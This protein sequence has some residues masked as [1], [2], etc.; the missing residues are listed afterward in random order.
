MPQFD[1][2]YGEVLT[3]RETSELT[4]FTMNQLR[5]QRQRGNSPLPYV[6]DGITSWYR[7]ADVVKYIET[8]GVLDRTYFVP[9][10]F[11]PAPIEASP[12]TFERREDFTAMAKI[13]TRNAWSKWTE[14]LTQHGGMDINEAY[15]FLEDETVRLYELKHGE[16]LREVHPGQSMDFWLRKN[17]PIRFWEG[18]TYATR[19]LARRLYEWNVTDED[20]INTPIGEVPPTKLD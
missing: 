3:S 5:N 16:N 1:P 15:K 7:K 18:R 14:T 10:G 12:L 13:T 4:G 6:T 19:S 11:E 2:V 17:D 20:I 9:E 8:K